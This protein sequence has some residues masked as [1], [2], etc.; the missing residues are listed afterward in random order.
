LAVVALV[1]T[2]R[3]TQAAGVAKPGAGA[4]NNTAPMFGSLEQPRQSRLALAGQEQTMQPDRDQALLCK[5]S[6]LPVAVAVAMV[7]TEQAHLLGQ[8]AILAVLE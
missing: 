7:P 1:F 4:V 8:T 5:D 3:M 2:T 6:P